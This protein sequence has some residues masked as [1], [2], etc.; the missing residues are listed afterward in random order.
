MEF[1]N[2]GKLCSICNIQDF[3]PTA[4]A[5]C[6]LFFCKEHIST[7]NH[8]CKIKKPIIN[9]IKCPMCN[10]TLRIK[11]NANETVSHHLD[12]NC[13][14]LHRHKYCSIKKC[15]KS[16]FTICNKCK[17]GYCIDHRNNHKCSP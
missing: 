10:K 11:N 6:N 15:K 1:S 17:K 13:I 5:N 4:C 3:C 7:K 9:F 12:N 14:K 8:D 16:K 2:I